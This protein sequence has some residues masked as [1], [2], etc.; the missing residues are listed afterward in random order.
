MYDI[1]IFKHIFHITNFS[2]KDILTDFIKMNFNK[3]EIISDILSANPF[4]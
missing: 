2:F 4:N 3:V 1:E